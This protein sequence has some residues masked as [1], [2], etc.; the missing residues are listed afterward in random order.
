MQTRAELYELVR[1][2]DYARLDEQL[3]GFAAADDHFTAQKE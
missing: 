3:A 2:A 1:Y